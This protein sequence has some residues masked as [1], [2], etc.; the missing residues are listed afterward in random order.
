[1][2][3]AV[4]AGDG[5][6]SEITT[7]ALRVLDVLVRDGLHAEIEHGLVGGAAVDATSDPLPEATE[8]LCASAD[9]IL[10]GAVGGP[11]Y[12]ALPRAQRPEQGLLRLRKRFDL[13]AN[14]RPALV[15]GELAHA[16][17]L[18]HE[19]VLG[20]DLLIVRELT[21]DIYFG[22]PRGIRINEAGEREGF[23]TMRYTEG[24]IRRI[25]HSAFQAARKRS[26]RVTSIDKSNVLETPSFGRMSSLRWGASIPMSLWCTC[27]STTLQCSWCV[28][29]DSSTSYWPAT[30]VATFCRMR[31]RC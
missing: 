12:D 23:D 22:Q 4:L 26:D 27:W 11:Q 20:L 16:S 30:C 9:A 28:T 13:F 2:K 21:S 17:P 8:R 1:M 24:E 31:L 5:I 6:G 25:A 10:F 29:L 7:Q 3:I 18:K 19:L 14:L 15:Y